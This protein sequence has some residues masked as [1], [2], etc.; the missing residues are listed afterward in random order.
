LTTR[1][2]PEMMEHDANSLGRLAPKFANV[3]VVAAP[4]YLRV[5]RRSVHP[6]TDR[7]SSPAVVLRAAPGGRTGVSCGLGHGARWRQAARRRRSC[8]ARVR[9]RLTRSGF[10]LKEP[11]SSGTGVA[12]RSDVVTLKDRLTAAHQVGKAEIAAFRPETARSPLF[13]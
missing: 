12:L 6:E 7:R 5:L 9:W 13:R 10:H 3:L 8:N 2:V 4:A 11:R 1:L